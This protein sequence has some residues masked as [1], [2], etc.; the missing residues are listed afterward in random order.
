MK[1]INNRIN[2]Y[3]TNKMKHLFLAAPLLMASV[4]FTQDAENLIENG[5]FETVSGKV[6]GLGQIEAATGWVTGTKAK[7][8]LF[9]SDT[10]AVTIGK[11]NQF[12]KEEP[13][14][15]E[16]YAGITIYS[17]GDKAPRSYLTTKLSTPLKKGMHYCVTYWVSLAEMSKYATNQLGMHISKSSLATADDVK[18]ISAEA[19]IMDFNNKIFKGTYGWEKVCAVFEAK[20]GEKFIAIGNFAK[21]DAVKNEKNKVTNDVKGTPLASSYYYIDDVSLK[22]ITDDKQCDCGIPVENTA[23]TATI[24]QKVVTINDKMTTTQKIDAQLLFYGHGKEK[25]VPQAQASLDMIAKEM[26]ANSK[27]RLE[28]TGY[29]DKT[30]I[31]MAVAKVSYANMGQKRAESVISYLVSKGVDKSRMTAVNGG[32]VENAKEV[33]A[34]DPDEL[35]LAKNRRVTFKV[36]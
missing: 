2:N 18:G 8:D 5:S 1:T 29:A 14:E 15:G 17:H 24:Y 22:L 27:L 6:K 19:Q 4:A 31:E 7:A 11:V 30:E 33:K 12:G 16:N 3:K 28:V 36:I 32:D 9:L 34:S 13:K 23:V 25:F 10:K 21:N 26:V 35:K 20:G